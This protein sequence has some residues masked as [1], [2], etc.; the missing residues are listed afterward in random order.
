MN[1]NFFPWFHAR[2]CSRKV[3]SRWKREKPRVREPRRVLRDGIES[4]DTSARRSARA[5]RTD[6]VQRALQ[7]VAFI[8]RRR[9]SVPAISAPLSRLRVAAMREMADVLHVRGFVARRFMRRFAGRFAWRFARWFARRLTRLIDDFQSLRFVL[10]LAA[11]SSVALSAGA[12]FFREDAHGVLVIDDGHAVVVLLVGVVVA[13]VLIL[14]VVALVAH[15]LVVLLTSGR[16]SGVVLGA[17]LTR[18]QST[19]LA[20]RLFPPAFALSFPVGD[21]VWRLASA[22]RVQR[23]Q[24]E[25]GR[26]LRPVALS[27]FTTSPCLIPGELLSRNDGVARRSDV[28]R[29][30]YTIGF[31]FRELNI[32]R[33]FRL[34]FKRYFDIIQQCHVSM[35]EES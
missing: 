33:Q 9:V 7:S 1:F 26:G 30:A 34:T 4:E 25:L 17:T 2:A 5:A 14:L 28:M 35:W 21:P 16:Y 15:Q 10:R 19:I 27:D 18:V 23:Q 11:L 32:T 24:R 22:I 8:F 6:P 31:T 29:H 3:E 20:S 12:V 13:D